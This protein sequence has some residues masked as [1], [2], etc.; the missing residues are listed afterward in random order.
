M[1]PWI[2]TLL[3]WAAAVVTAYV[4]AT[5]AATQS[6]IGRLDGMGIPISFAERLSM[7]A[8]D[9]LGMCGLYL[10]LIT[11]ALL[12][13][14]PVAGWL[15]RRSPERRPLLFMLAGA[16]AILCIHLAL[17]WSF[18]ITLVAVARTPLGLLSQVLAGAAAGYLYTRLKQ[19]P[20][21]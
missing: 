15:G 9:L 18:D 2:R 7:S 12:L 20:A 17:N 14:W 4:L 6:V 11:V 13:A 5:L 10:P 19:A 16:T 3:A 21:R 1:K 8:Q